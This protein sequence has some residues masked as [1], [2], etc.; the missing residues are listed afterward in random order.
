MYF[1][2]ALICESSWNR[3]DSTWS[4]MG[5]FFFLARSWTWDFC[6]CR[7]KESRANWAAPIE[8]KTLNP[9]RSLARLLRAASPVH[10]PVVAPTAC[11]FKPSPNAAIAQRLQ[12]HQCLSSHCFFVA[13][14]QRLSGSRPMKNSN[15]SRII[16]RRST[17]AFYM[18]LELQGHS[19]CGYIIPPT[20]IR[21]ESYGRS[22]CTL[23]GRHT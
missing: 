18:I 11:S 12:L 19:A 4:V 17:L 22:E 8:N 9:I 13:C 16:R 14:A 3:V 23:I 1:N 2:S 10:R 20:R 6:E 5:R 7:R 21:F 15:P